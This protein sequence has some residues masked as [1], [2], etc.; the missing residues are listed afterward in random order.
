MGLGTTTLSSAGDA[1]AEA[2][3]QPTT[4][5]VLCGA[6]GHCAIPA[7]AA[8]C[9]PGVT[10]EAAGAYKPRVEPYRLALRRLRAEPATTLFVAGT[11]RDIGGA[12]GAGMDV[13]WHNR[14]R[15]S[16][17]ECEPPLAEF[18]SLEDLLALV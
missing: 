17:G 4:M 16:L 3:E 7:G 14:L 15:L 11:P 9:P 10:A 13:A 1:D 18:A 2:G 8:E 6:S 12:R 5:R